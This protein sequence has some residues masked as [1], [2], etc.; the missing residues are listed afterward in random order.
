MKT[1][2]GQGDRAGPG[3][4]EGDGILRDTEVFTGLCD[5]SKCLISN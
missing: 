4:C 1:D 2:H 5:L 3:A